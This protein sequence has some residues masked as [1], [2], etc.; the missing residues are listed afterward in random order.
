MTKITIV[1]ILLIL[2]IPS[3]A[4][5]IVKQDKNGKIIV[6]NRASRNPWKKIAL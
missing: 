2:V 1:F 6:S 5:I 3:Q 4:E